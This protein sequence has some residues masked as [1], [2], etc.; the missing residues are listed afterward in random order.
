MVTTAGDAPDTKQPM[1][2][3]VLFGAFCSSLNFYRLA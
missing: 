1:Q 2:F 3:L